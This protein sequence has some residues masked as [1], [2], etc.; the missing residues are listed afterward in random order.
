[1]PR[2]KAT[3]LFNCAAD[4]AREQP[5]R[6]RGSAARTEPGSHGR[7]P[8]PA[9]AR[10]RG[11]SAAGDRGQQRG[12]GDGLGQ[13]STAPALMA[14]DAHR[15]VAVAGHED[16]REP[17]RPRAIP[18]CN[19]RPLIP[20][21]CT[22][23]TTQPGWAME[24]FGEELRRGR[25]T[26]H[27]VTGRP[28]EPGRGAPHVAVVLDDVCTTGAARTPACRRLGGASRRLFGSRTGSRPSSEAA[29]VGNE[30]GGALERLAQSGHRRPGRA[31]VTGQCLW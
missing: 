22:S 11:R 21:S 27:R 15:D 3:C 6:S 30:S 26:L 17:V 19:S 1:M 31:I 24:A 16:D 10:R 12:A 9:A 28:Q 20:G 8:A 14:A 13:K 25:M 29:I 2:S 5:L 7:A 4:Q 23:S 18:S